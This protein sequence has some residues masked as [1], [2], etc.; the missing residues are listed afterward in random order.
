MIFI[1]RFVLP[2]ERGMKTQTNRCSLGLLASMTTLE[3]RHIELEHGLYYGIL[4]STE[5]RLLT[6]PPCL[7]DNSRVQ[8]KI[9]CARGMWICRARTRSLVWHIAQYRA[10]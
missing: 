1:L 3:C 6:W 4:H 7:N 2:E 8:A 9:R 10:S 5:L